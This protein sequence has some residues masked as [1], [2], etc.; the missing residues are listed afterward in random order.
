MAD[1]TYTWSDD[2]PVST[3]VANTLDTI[4]RNNVKRA[5]NERYSLEHVALDDANVDQSS[6]T[7]SGR[8]K[9][10]YVSCVF[11]GTRTEIDNISPALTGAIAYDTDADQL[12][13]YNGADWTQLAPGN[14]TV[15]EVFEE[16][17][18]LQLAAPMVEVPA[19]TQTITLERDSLCD[20]TFTGW[21]GTTASGRYFIAAGIYTDD[22]LRV[23]TRNLPSGSLT[24]EGISMSWKGTLEAGE[25]DFQIYAARIAAEIQQS[26][27]VYLT[28]YFQV[29]IR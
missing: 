13:Y 9:P 20:C 8:H 18:S 29:E 11:A 26:T 15:S 5:L 24:G 27:P 6:P 25:H 28:G 16:D 19:F 10:G 14:S 23:E 7:A 4:I 22:T 2:T 21:V 1:H 17:Q 12:L 3:D